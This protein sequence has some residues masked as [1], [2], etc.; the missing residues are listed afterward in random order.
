MDKATQ[1]IAYWRTEEWRMKNRTDC[2]ICIAII[3]IYQRK[4]NLVDDV[5]GGLFIITSFFHFGKITH[6][7]KFSCHIHPSILWAFYHL[8]NT[9]IIFF[10]RA[11]PNYLIII[12]HHAMQANP[13][14]CKIEHNLQNPMFTIFI[15]FLISTGF[16]I[17]LTGIQCNGI[18]VL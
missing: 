11:V 3:V 12:H 14:I 4:Y 8:R 13:L 7:T 5:I 1:N 10:S 9:H 16:T 2:S 15:N 6:M 18:G 17:L